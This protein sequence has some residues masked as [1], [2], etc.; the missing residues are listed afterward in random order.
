MTLNKLNRRTFLRLAASTIGPAIAACDAGAQPPVVAQSTPPAAPTGTP[1]ATATPVRIALAGGDA[2]VW[3][4][5]R[6]VSG[7]L[8][9]DCAKAYLTVG[10]A[11]AELKRDGE[12]FS[13]LAMLQE[14]KNTVT[15]ICSQQD[16]REERSSVQTFTVPLKRRPTAVPTIS[17]EADGIVLDGSA[18]QPEEAG[19]TPISEYFWSFRANN[20]AT[21]ASP[22]AQK[23]DDQLV[24]KRVVVVAP[25]VDGEFYV[26]LR[27]V[28]AEGRA[29]TGTSY[30]VIAGGQPRIPNYDTENTAW[31]ERAIVYGVIA[32]KFG[33][34]AFQAVTDRLDYL[35]D[36]GINAL[37]FSPITNS[38]AGDFGYAVIDY[39]NVHPDLGTMDDFKKLV[40]EAHARGI[41]VLIDFVPNHTSDEHPYFKDAQARGKD[42]PYYDYYDRDAAGKPTHYFDWQNLPNLNYDNPEVERFML[43]AFSYWVREIDVDG[44]RTDACWGVK[45]RK[46]DYWPRWR[47]ELKRIKPDLL[48]LAEA[49]ARDPYYFDNGFDVAYDWT[50]ALGKWAW[51]LIWDSKTLLIY[52]LS[53]ALTNNNQGFHPDA[54]IFRFLNNNDTGTRFITTHGREMT[55]VAAALLL[56]LPGVPCVYTGDEVG[57][58]YRPYYDEMPMVWDEKKY[59]GLRDY[60]KKLI[61]LRNDT[62]SL[63][64]RQWQPLEATP[65]KQVYAYLRYIEPAQQPVLVVLNFSDQELEAEVALPDAFAAF[66]RQPALR[67]LLADETLAITAPGTLKLPMPAW[68]ARICERRSIPTAD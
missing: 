55:Q 37:W 53:S 42:S 20:P 23:D 51:E 5:Q 28:D 2:D 11:Q 41:R 3:G 21:L 64:S 40:Q 34:P 57:A 54:L 13:A 68:G 29:D 38:P 39:F 12:H 7:Q 45:E 14:G 63:H 4:W 58:W 17:I 62:P 56:T 9:G 19:G 50:A 66:G 31:V 24:G 15:A 60:Y 47:R 52:N 48:L 10:D 33:D 46:P 65:N 32:R 25:T 36:L 59:P 61:A 1:S 44:F 27:V 26:S 22:S 35:K 49:S 30:F 8:V 43:E 16:G 67:D 18:S 6:Q